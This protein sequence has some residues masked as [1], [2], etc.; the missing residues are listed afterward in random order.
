MKKICVLD[1]IPEGRE[2]AVSR[3]E[4]VR[5]TGKS[6]R[7]IRREIKGFLTAGV[8]IMSSSHSGGYWLSDNPDEWTECINEYD[9]R[10]ATMKKTVWRLRQKR[11]ARLGIKTIKVSAHERRLSKAIAKVPEQQTAMQI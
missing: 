6:D 8:P 10:I 11:N 3:R 7:E 2:N 1:Y 5:L 9:R 4:L